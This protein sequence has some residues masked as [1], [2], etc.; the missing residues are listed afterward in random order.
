MLRRLPLVSR[1]ISRVAVL[2]RAPLLIRFQSTNNRAPAVSEEEIV[3]SKI[4]LKVQPLPRP[5]EETETKRARLLYQS[6]K[7]GILETDLILSKFAKVY[8]GTMSREEMDEYDEL[9]DEQD[10]DIYY[11]ATRNNDVKPCPER[12]E[13]SPL[14]A[15]LRD[16]AEN[17]EKE[18]LRM[19][20]L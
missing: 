12:W 8:L 1:P 11:W 4:E 18:V 2:S 20:D 13:K 7:R 15:K 17:R 10:W 19:P 5:G 3:T 16:L 6:R 14:M 9:L